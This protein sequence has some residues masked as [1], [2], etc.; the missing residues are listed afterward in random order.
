MPVKV[1]CCYAREDEP[2]L[3]QLKRHLRP[4]QRQGMID[5]SHDRDI[6]AGAEWE[7]EID[8]HLNTSEIILLLISSDFMDSDYCYS[9]EMK[10]ALERH[11]RG[12]AC[13]IPII[14]RPVYWKDALFSKLQALPKD[15]KPVTTW[16]NE[17]E[18][19]LNVAEG[20]HQAVGKL[21]GQVKKT[22]TIQ[23]QALFH[24]E[25]E[26][27]IKFVVE[28][29]KTLGFDTTEMVF[30][31]SFFLKMG[32][33]SYKIETGQQV[34]AAQARLDILVSR[35]GNNLFI[36]EVKSADISISTADI[37]QA[38]SYARLVDPIAPICIITNGKAWKIVNSI[39]K[40]DISV[41]S[42]VANTTYV[43]TLPDDVYFE[44]L[45][46]FLGYSQENLLQFCQQQVPD[47]MEDLRGS[48]TDRTK[49]YIES[50]YEPREH[51]STTFANF[52]QSDSSCFAVVGDSGSGKSCWIC[53]TALRYLQ[54]HH[55][56]LF[57]RGFDIENGIFKAIREDLNWS[58]SLQYDE[59]QGVKRLL[60]VFRHDCIL[61]FIDGLDEIPV[62][63]ARKAIDEFLKRVDGKRMKL[64]ATCKTT[65]W[66][67]LL[68]R[69]GNPTRL[70]NR[71][72]PVDGSKG[73]ILRYFHDQEFFRVL[74]KY[75]S[76]Y[77]YSGPFETEVYED[78]QRNPFLLRIMFE[79]AS[80]QQLPYISYTV[81][82]VYQE[83]F[84]N[85]IKRF[86]SSQRDMIQ[87]I[88]IE[89]ARCFYIH[90]ADELDIAEL[91]ASMSLSATEPLPSRLFE[92]N[93]LE[94]HDR[95]EITYISFYFKKLRDY[96]IAFR[97]LKWQTLPPQTFKSEIEKEE[98]TGVRQDAL[99]LYYSVTPSEEHKRVLDGQL[100]SKAFAFLSLYE[101]ILDTDFPV[102]KQ[103]FPPDTP[104]QIGFVGYVDF[105]HKA[106]S[107]HGFRPLKVGDAKVLLLPIVPI[108]HIRKRENK[109]YLTGSLR[110]QS[111]DSSRGFQNIDIV[112]EVLS[113]NIFPS[114]KKI[115]EHGRLDESQN[116]ELLIE[117]VLS[118]CVT[119]CQDY[120]QKYRQAVS[121]SYL[122]LRLT[123]LRE[124]ILYKIAYIV[125]DFQVTEKKMA[126]N[127]AQEW[128]IGNIR[129]VSIVVSPQELAEIEEQAWAIAKQG[130]NMA[131]G[132]E[133]LVQNDCDFLSL[134]EDI[135]NLDKLN[136]VEISSTPLTAWYDKYR[137]GIPRLQGPE[138]FAEINQLLE[139][140]YLSFLNEYQ[141][142]VEKNFPTLYQNFEYYSYLPA[143]LSVALDTAQYDP[144]P[145][146]NPF[147]TLGIVVQRQRKNTEE[148][149]VVVL[150]TK[151]EIYA[152]GNRRR[153]DPT[154][155]GTLLSSSVASSI[156][157][158]HHSYTS[159]KA[160]NSLSILSSMIYKQIEEDI[161]EVLATLVV[162]YIS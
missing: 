155:R 117:R 23:Q 118:T 152:E 135:D 150:S 53:D 35:D 104:G 95:D 136:V 99:N 114:L 84:G 103:S 98:I 69:D 116:K 60:D 140:L 54:S 40:A 125:L 6:S 145:Q 37:D 124:Y 159:F 93:I 32:R 73:Y 91:K 123:E 157:S 12:E 28:Y 110:I 130:G 30:E 144:N 86:D 96:L 129:S 138:L 107:M 80:Q 50:V 38:V 17:D 87:H 70:S 14:L 146:L 77:R 142:L 71:I 61:V 58:L 115:I 74:E 161:K 148:R 111:T 137:G 92:L 18:A 88:L 94:K 39:T 100:Y 43:P 63:L 139:S 120:F 65:V 1:F 78:C 132:R 97:A 55:T 3:D 72:F 47:A 27:K 33:F 81:I 105:A 143:K 31:K 26:V 141:I 151:E 49:K 48:E 52:V 44:A 66:K 20:I 162:K 11:E 8:K 113:Q 112:D 13:V 62:N 126:A 133:Q 147:F 59:V 82:N 42:I 4:L 127:E 34:E 24:N 29:L 128:W 15:G 79:V 90:N 16:A 134:L 131:Y 10:R 121:S 57:Y 25:E 67:D 108:T 45:Q 5:I 101:K 83:Y 51:L 19:F 75:R 9:I 122:P 109:A 76:F 154:F 2:L 64:I 36:V 7:R 153:V 160:R 89:I 102:F 68:N 85:L 119:H 149:N 46:H 158:P 56:V 21:T 41:E 106:I 156:L 22:S